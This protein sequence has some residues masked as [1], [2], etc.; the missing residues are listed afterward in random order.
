[1]LP[2]IFR[3]LGIV[4]AAMFVGFVSAVEQHL[5]HLGLP[6]TPFQGSMGYA[7]IA[8]HIRLALD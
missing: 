4:K 1:M 7:L 5:L 8:D 3:K 2:A 6:E